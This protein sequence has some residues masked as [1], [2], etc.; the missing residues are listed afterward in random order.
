M[1]KKW[2]MPSP[3]GKETIPEI[4]KLSSEFKLPRLVAELL[5]QKG[6]KTSAAVQEFFKP[7]MD[8]LYDPFLFPDM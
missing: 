2:L 3:P 5:Y 8:N 4:E 6:I 7:S 1:N